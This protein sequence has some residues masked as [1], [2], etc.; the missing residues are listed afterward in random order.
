MYT[1]PGVMVRFAALHKTGGP[2]ENKAGQTWRRV[3]FLQLRGHDGVRVV[4]MSTPTH[5]Q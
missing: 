4:K 3:Q 2:G 5:Q 1:L